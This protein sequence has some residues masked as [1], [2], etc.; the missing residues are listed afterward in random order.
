MR[1]SKSRSLLRVEYTSRPAEPPARRTIERLSRSDKRVGAKTTSSALLCYEDKSAA[2]NSKTVGPGV[3]ATRLSA[4]QFVSG[5]DTDLR[6]RR[7]VV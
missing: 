6:R 1:R 3:G 4:H 5:G 2:N 7:R